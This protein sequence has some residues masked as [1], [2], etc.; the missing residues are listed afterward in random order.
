MPEFADPA[1]M[2]NVTR[3]VVATHCELASAPPPPRVVSA[4][5]RRDRYD[6]ELVFEPP[7]GCE[8]FEVVWRETTEP[9]LTHTIDMAT[10]KPRATASRRLLAT[11]PGVCL[12]DVVVGVRSV[13]ADGSRSRTATPPEPD[14]FEQRPRAARAAEDK[15]GQDK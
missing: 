5:L 11:F 14:R 4:Q 2:A 15:G 3:V 13:G 12:D 6:T 7:A 8:R 1:Y 9:D 10:A